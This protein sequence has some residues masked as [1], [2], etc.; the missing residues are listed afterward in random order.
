MLVSEILFTYKHNLILLTRYLRVFI[1]SSAHLTLFTVF[2]EDLVP[3][4]HVYRCTAN[5][6]KKQKTRELFQVSRVLG[7]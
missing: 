1:L 2:V 4:F 5:P 7:E 3:S 6:P